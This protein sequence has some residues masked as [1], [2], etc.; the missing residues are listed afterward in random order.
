MNP[1]MYRAY[2]V[3]GGGVFLTC[4]PPFF[5]YTQL[6]RRYR[7]HFSE[8]LGYVPARVVRKLVGTPRI[9]LHAVSLGEIR[10]AVPIVKALYELMPHCAVLVSTTTEHGRVQA[11]EVFSESQVPVVYG[12][13]DF[14]GS[15]RIAM[16]R[17]RPDVMVFL[18]TEIWPAWVIEARRLGVGTALINGRISVRSIA[19]YLKFRP[20]F[21][22][23]LRHMDVL[24][25]ITQQDAERIRALGAPSSRILVNGNAKYDGLET[26]MDA[27]VEQRMR[28]MLRLKGMSTPVMVAGS[29]RDGEEKMILEAYKKI[30]KRF[31]ETILIIAPRHVER[32]SRIEALVARHGL[33]SER[34]TDISS[35]GGKRTRP[36]VILDTFGELSKAYSVA[37]VV[38][39]GASLVPKGG[40]NPLEAAALGKGVF[41][42]PSMEDFE[43]ARKLLEDHDAGVPVPS[44]EALAEKVC[45]YLSRPDLLKALGDRARQAV[46]NSRRAAHKH[47]RVIANLA[48]GPR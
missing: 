22:E 3:L 29:T 35:P 25:M 7:D 28:G 24:S 11:S 6:S 39:C 10:V 37:S 26:R 47:A 5:L 41:Y 46:T 8:R 23:V 15:V 31:P 16:S 44:A 45:R 42:G 21:R 48:A 19:G 32:V 20:L 40:Q 12:P 2:T 27:R 33:Q 13:I 18:E 9:W 43:D 38:F 17:V 14:V 34:W 30:L 1:L 36:V 4:L